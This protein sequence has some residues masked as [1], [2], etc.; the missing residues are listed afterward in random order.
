MDQWPFR[1]IEPEAVAGE[2]RVT[3]LDLGVAVFLVKKPRKKA[4]SSALA[5][6]RPFCA[7]KASCSLSCERNVFSSKAVLPRISRFAC[8]AICSCALE[9]S[10]FSFCFCS[11][12]GSLTAP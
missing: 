6:V 12:S 2:D 9:T 1:D 5:L 7:M 4:A 10:F 3:D 11:S 8:W